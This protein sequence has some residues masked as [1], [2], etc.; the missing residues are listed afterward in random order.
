M[1]TSL[2]FF[3]SNFLWWFHILFVCYFLDT[4]Y[5]D[6]DEKAFEK[7]NNAPNRIYANMT[8]HLQSPP[9]NG[10]YENTNNIMNIPKTVSTKTLS[11]FYIWWFFT[12]LFCL[13]VRLL[14]PMDK[15]KIKKYDIL[16][17]LHLSLLSF[18]IRPF[19]HFLY[20]SLL[21]SGI[22]IQE[23][24]LNKFFHLRVP[25]LLVHII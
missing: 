2:S 8:P 18:G 17:L 10:M 1:S 23:H 22:A 6:P 4:D 24:K 12:Y 3:L 13:D 15:F 16:L 21:S 11:I 19:I 7:L 20:C 5:Q 25:N 9:N 14:R